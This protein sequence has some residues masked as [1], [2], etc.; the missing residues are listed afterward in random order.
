MISPPWQDNVA[1]KYLSLLPRSEFPN[2]RHQVVSE[3]LL[4]L[5]LIWQVQIISLLQAQV[6][7]KN[8]KKILN[9]TSQTTWNFKCINKFSLIFRVKNDVTYYISSGLYHSN[10]HRGSFSAMFAY[11]STSLQ[12]YPVVWIFLSFVTADEFSV[13]VTKITSRSGVSWTRS[14]PFYL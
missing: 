5:R 8:A 6:I 7:W 1:L 2:F 12:L 13:R 4:H 10:W 11:G 3:K 9:C 14:L